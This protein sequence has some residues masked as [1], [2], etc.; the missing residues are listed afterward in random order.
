[1]SDADESL[2]LLRDGRVSHG[3]G[4]V[5]DSADKMKNELDKIDDS[6]AESLKECCQNIDELFP[7]IGARSSGNVFT[8]PPHISAYPFDRFISP[9]ITSFFG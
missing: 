7:S 5:V 2:L 1:M 6:W 9:G 4:L 8:L 3:S